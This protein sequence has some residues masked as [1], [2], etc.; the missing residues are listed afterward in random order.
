M[1][2][3]RT[4]SKAKLRDM[5]ELIAQGRTDALICRLEQMYRN[6]KSRAKCYLKGL[7]ERWP[8]ASVHIPYQW[9]SGEEPDA[10]LHGGG[11]KLYRRIEAREFVGP[12]V[13]ALR[14]RDNADPTASPRT[15]PAAPR[16]PPQRHR[17]GPHAGQ[18]GDGAAGGGRAAAPAAWETSSARHLVL[19]VDA[20]QILAVCAGRLAFAAATWPPHDAARSAAQA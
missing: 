9:Y 10:S 16:P 3:R 17:P 13:P 18:A 6:I 15:P 1:P 19:C 14:P 12:D 20:M 5:Y 8:P 2:L 7:E 11:R 4:L